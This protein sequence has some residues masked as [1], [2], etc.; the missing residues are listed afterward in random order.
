MILVSKPNIWGSSDFRLWTQWTEPPRR[1]PQVSEGAG[2][3]GRY[4]PPPPNS[5]TKR[6]SK[7]KKSAKSC[8]DTWVSQTARI[9]DCTSTTRNKP[10][11]EPEPEF[12]FSTQQMLSFLLWFCRVTVVSTACCCRQVEKWEWR[13]IS[14]FNLKSLE[15]QTGLGVFSPP[16]TPTH[17]SNTGYYVW[18]SGNTEQ[19]WS[20]TVKQ[21]CR[22]LLNSWSSWDLI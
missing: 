20:F 8:K 12:V 21:S 2:W 6:W 18:Q 7:F 17:G 10:E 11:P 5:C 19:F 16:D 22:V 15:K 4:R 13:W 1:H 14:F 3:G 9:S